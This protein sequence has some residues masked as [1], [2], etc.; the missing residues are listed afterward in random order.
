L[1]DLDNTKLRPLKAK[2]QDVSTEERRFHEVL[3]NKNIRTE[4]FQVNFIVGQF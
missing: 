2:L 3:R 1:A 4:E